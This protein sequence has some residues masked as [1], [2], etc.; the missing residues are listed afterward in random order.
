[1]KNLLPILLFVCIFYSA[2]AQSNAIKKDSIALPPKASY[3]V[4]NPILLI[5]LN[6]V[7]VNEGKYVRII[8]T[9]RAYKV[10]DSTE[11]IAFGDVYPREKLTIVLEKK[12]FEVFKTKNI[13]GKRI[14]VSGV[15]ELYKGDD[16]MYI[17]NPSQIY[18]IPSH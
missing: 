7:K 12:A 17:T 9:V 2:S 15:I 8:D 13:D 4:A 10:L 5:A 3:I 11:A 16:Q 18:I 1:M 14:S 6:D